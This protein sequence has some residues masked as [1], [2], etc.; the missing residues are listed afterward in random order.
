MSMD[1]G[2]QRGGLKAD[3]NVTP[4]VDVMLVLL[5]IMM[6]IAPLLQKG[7]NVNLPTASNVGDK[8]DT[9]QQVVVHVTANGQFYVNNIEVPAK[10]V[11]DRIKYALEEARE[12]V[13]YLKADGDAQYSAIM[14][15]MDDLREAQIENVGLITETKKK[16]GQTQGGE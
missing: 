10:D 8:P 9:Q 15:M 16:E 2:G 12:K 5:I 1:V 7:V 6:L 14:K 11:V 4:L 3:I 13:I